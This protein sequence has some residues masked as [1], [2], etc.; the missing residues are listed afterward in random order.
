M[1][2][3]KS[4]GAL[5]WIEAGGVPALIALG[6]GHPAYWPRRIARREPDTPMG[7]ET[8]DIGRRCEQAVIAAYRD[9][10]VHGIGDFDAFR[11]CTTLYRIHHPEASLN[12]AR[13]LV[14]EWIDHDLLGEHTG[15][16]A[17]CGCP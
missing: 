11:A 2:P 6:P 4:D 8:S 16:G 7:R 14:A 3:P 17:G 12:E 13:R 5:R 1:W 15:T 9:L 10:R